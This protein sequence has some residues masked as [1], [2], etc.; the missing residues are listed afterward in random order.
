MPYNPQK[1]HRHSIRL[2][3][4]D[5]TLP[6]AYFVTICVRDRECLLG[7]VVGEETRLSAFGQIA[8]SF[9]TQVVAH[10]PGV[11]V[12]VFTIMP[13]HLHALIVI[14]EPSKVVG[15]G[16]EDEE[17]SPLQDAR[18]G[19]EDCGRAAPAVQPTTE[20]PSLGQIVA[21]YKYQTTVQVNQLRD[22][23]GVP[24]WQRNYWE[25]VIRNEASLNR[26]REYI[27]NNPAR[28][29]EDQLHPAAS[30]NRFNR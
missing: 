14:Q 30:P 19:D 4:Y 29:A 21:Y 26:I 3:G 24:F 27:D 20:R 11:A 22:M 7:E 17:T 28:W 9:W 2:P 13:N 1:H 16:E 5:Y 10:F 18:G 15:S 6:G 8:H 25:H 23:P 12:D